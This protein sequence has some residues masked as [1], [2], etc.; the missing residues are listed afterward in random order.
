[1]KDGKFAK[2]ALLAS[3]WLGFGAGS[4]QAGNATCL[5]RNLV[6]QLGAELGLGTPAGTL[7]D[8]GG[9]LDLH[10]ALVGLTTQRAVLWHQFRVWVHGSE[11]GLG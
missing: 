6:Q 4:A 2:A 7:L 3:A 9:A 1:M 10:R 11:L 5:G 8:A